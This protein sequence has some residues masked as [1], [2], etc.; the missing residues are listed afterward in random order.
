[1]PNQQQA[2]A[3]GQQPA[4]GRP[5]VAGRLYRDDDGHPHAEAQLEPWDLRDRA[6][7]V[8]R[9][10]LEMVF[11]SADERRI[12]ALLDVLDWHRP[13]MR[14]EQVFAPRYVGSRFL[15]QG[16]RSCGPGKT[17]CGTARAVAAALGITS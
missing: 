9:E 13:W 6:L 15:G 4:A 12:R 5:L 2:P 10:D 3:A 7:A 17:E 8:L 14:W 16:C 11:D 1:M